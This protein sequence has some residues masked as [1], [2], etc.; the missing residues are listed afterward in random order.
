MWATARSTNT[1][2]HANVTHRG[3]EMSETV[4]YKMNSNRLAGTRSQARWRILQP[5]HEAIPTA[6]NG[7]FPA[8]SPNERERMKPLNWNRALQ[9]KARRSYSWHKPT[10][11]SRPPETRQTS[12]CF[13]GDANPLDPLLKALDNRAESIALYP[14]KFIHSELNRTQRNYCMPLH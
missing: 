11:E 2:V 14:R 10:W 6:S 7:D 1:D 3:G 9:H 12:R 8:Q 13:R 4:L 5:L